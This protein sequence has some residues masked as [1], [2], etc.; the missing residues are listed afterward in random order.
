M[1]DRVLIADDAVVNRKILASILG[2]AGFEC[3]LAVDG[4]EALRAARREP[5]DLILL[6]VVMPGK[7]G[8]AVCAELK[9]DPVLADIPV[10]FLSSLDEA[11][12]KIKGLT[13][14][15]ADYVTKP[16]DR[17][18]ILAR[19][20]TQLRLRHLTRSLQLLNQELLEKQQSLDDDLSAAADIQRALIPR[21]ELRLPGVELSWLFIPSSAVGGDIFNAQQLDAEHVAFYILDVNG[22]GVPAAMV[23]LLVW[24]S[25]SPA[26]GLV[27][28][29]GGAP[30]VAPPAEVLA[31]LEPEFPYERF[32]RYFTISYLVLHVPSGRLA[33]STAAHPL[34]LLARTD[35]TLQPLEEGG[36]IIGLGL[37]SYEQGEVWLERGDRVFLFTDGIGEYRSPGGELFGDERLR[38]T[39][40]TAAGLPLEGVGERLYRALKEFGAGGLAGDDISFLALE[41]H[42]PPG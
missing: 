31:G 11:A 8:Y 24:Q 18:E 42:G 30:V 25:L 23:A 17:G 41:Y 38:E 22:H 5:P 19:V 40:R 28:S 36:S 16:F 21:P 2:K 3:V 7:D 35:G 13:A 6:D 4:T 12:S 14:G 20:R 10:I 27:V 34:P 33:Y 29:G 1:A 26:M 32:E 39:L 9:A 15:A 37:G